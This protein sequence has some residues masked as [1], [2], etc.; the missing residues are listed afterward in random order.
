MSK[1]RKTNPGEVQ[2]SGAFLSVNASLQ[3]EK[4]PTFWGYLKSNNRIAQGV[5][6]QRFGKGL[7]IVLKGL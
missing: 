4:N 2:R 5:V 3:E 1:K 6:P 7:L